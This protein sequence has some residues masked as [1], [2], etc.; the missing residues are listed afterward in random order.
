LAEK[1]AAVPTA[2]GGDYGPFGDPAINIYNQVVARA[3]V[4]GGGAAEALFLFFAG[5]PLDPVEVTQIVLKGDP[6]PEDAPAD[7]CASGAGTFGG[8]PPVFPYTAF[9]DAIQVVYVANIDCPA[10]DPDTQ[11]VFIASLDWDGDRSPDF[12]DNCP[13]IPNADQNNTDK[14]LARTNTDVVGD[15]LGNSCDTDL[16]GDGLENLVEDPCPVSPDCDGDRFL[17]GREVYLGTDPLLGCA[18]TGWG[19]GEG[20][21]GVD[22][23]G[24]P[25]LWPIDFNDDQKASMQDVIFAF[26]TTLAPDGL[27][28]PATGLER[29]DMNGDGF[30]NMQDV[31]LGYV[32]KLAPTG[33]NT[34]CTP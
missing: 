25:D 16:D 21:D 10:A 34:M 22:D 7:S 32:T 19:T 28:Q 9:N 3:D 17:D 4:T 2:V 33:L 11:G 29:V 14:A 15:D 12:L 1:G 18:A 6:L 30:I 5:S 31:I 27:N 8:G 23:E 20:Q 26:V 24:P 13:L